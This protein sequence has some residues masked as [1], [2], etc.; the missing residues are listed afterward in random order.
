MMGVNILCSVLA[1]NTR[2]G[3][4]ALAEAG[5]WASVEMALMLRF[6]L[7]FPRIERMLAVLVGVAVK[8]LFGVVPLVVLRLS[9]LLSKSDLVTVQVRVCEEAALVGRKV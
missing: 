4:V 9:Q 3:I 8:L 5:H 6:P 2:I 1:T 7:W